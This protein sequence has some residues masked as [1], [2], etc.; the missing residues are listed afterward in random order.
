MLFPSQWEHPRLSQHVFWQVHCCTS[1]TR[2]GS[3]FSAVLH[4]FKFCHKIESTVG[5]EILV[6]WTNSFTVQHICSSIQCSGMATNKSV[7]M[8]T[9]CPQWCVSSVDSLPLLHACTPP[10]P[11]QLL[12]TVGCDLPMLHIA[13]HSTHVHF[14]LGELLFPLTNTVTL[15]WTS[16]LNDVCLQ[17]ACAFLYVYP[18]PQGNI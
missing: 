12:D 11:F 16:F 1:F 6:C 3:Y 9:E 10:S 5:P 8:D 13:L 7:W 18:Q 14:Y 15:L 4:I 17:N 2:C